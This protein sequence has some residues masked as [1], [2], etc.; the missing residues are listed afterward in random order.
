MR[1]FSDNFK[2]YETFTFI[3]YGSNM[4][5][6][7]R[8]NFIT[9]LL[10]F[11]CMGLFT[12]A[13]AQSDSVE[14]FLIDSYISPDKPNEFQVVFYTSDV[15]KSQIVLQGKYV[16]P[17]SDTL[18]D[19][20]KKVV[21]LSKYKFDSSATYFTITVETA[22]GVKITSDQYEIQAP[23]EKKVESS[24]GEFVSCLY[25]GVIFLV[26]T[27][28]VNFFKDK[29]H[30]GLS[31]ELPVVSFYSG[32]YNYPRSFISAEYSYVFDVPQKNYLRLGYKYL[33]ETDYGKFFIVGLNGFT[34]FRGYNG[35][36]PELTWGAFTF[37]DVFTIY[38]RYRYNTD[39]KN[40]A[41]SFSEVS[42][43]L[44]SWFFSVHD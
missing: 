23:V 36:S 25:G 15:C 40:P 10:V 4:I 5:I 16:I 41:N 22:S 11:V 44:Y 26:P 17:V 28:D 39:F 20:H 33:F 9:I 14:I 27:V 3:L 42:L 35:I 24:G 38:A 8:I 34:S 32:G 7:K 18:T 1:V 6:G 2:V 30:L 37:K 12:S 13:Q 29:A 19:N 31:K 43:G 21:D